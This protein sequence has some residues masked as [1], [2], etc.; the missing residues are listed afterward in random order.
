MHCWQPKPGA[1]E[2]GV[3]G[4]ISSSAS[5]SEVLPDNWE[6]DGQHLLFR[7]PLRLA[8]V[9]LHGVREVHVELAAGRREHTAALVSEEPHGSTLCY[10]KLSMAGYNRS[11]FGPL[12]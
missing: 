10:A 1:K 2:G 5:T 4:F 12:C 11:E 6:R 8:L 9:L 7:V 3:N